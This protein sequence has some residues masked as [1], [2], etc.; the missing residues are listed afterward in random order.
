MPALES[1]RIPVVDVSGTFESPTIPRVQP[2]DQAVGRLVAKHFLER[3]LKHFAFYGLGSVA[4]SK[5]RQAGYIDELQRA[6]F[7]CSVF[8][9]APRYTVKAVVA[10][11][12]FLARWLGAMEKPVGLMCCNDFRAGEVAFACQENEI[13]VPQDMALVGVSNDDMTCELATVPISS[14]DLAPARIG[15]IAASVV[16][17]ILRGVRPPKAPILIEPAGLVAR[18]SS[19]I[20]A[21]RNENV[22]SAIRFIQQ[23]AHE[24]I[25]VEDVL[26][27]VPIS[28]RALEINCK[29]MLGRTPREQITQVHLELAKTILSESD[30]PL[31]VIADRSGFSSASALSL[32]FAKQIGMRPGEYRKRHRHGTQFPGIKP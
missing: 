8:N 22:A 6:G 32:V 14:V 23:H 18:E 3:G 2:D 29:A 1:L 21:T 7:P 9:H 27:E 19:D 10:N 15:Y 31:T 12:E 26:R 24:A 30:L 25:E 5:H 28:R 13:H 16:H 20:L 11:R 4:Y 17:G